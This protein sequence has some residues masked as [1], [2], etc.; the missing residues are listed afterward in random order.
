V[1]CS[2]RMT[3]T[4]LA[5]IPQAFAL[6]W[7]SDGRLQTA[8]TPQ[9]SMICNHVRPPVFLLPERLK[10]A[11]VLIVHTWLL[12]PG[13][14]LVTVMKQRPTHIDVIKGMLSKFLQNL[15]C[16]PLPERR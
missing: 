6:G 15:C 10:T 16:L 12:A 5:R 7:T 2:A 11:I 14:A 1:C 3:D 8:H 4:G 13:G 9:Y